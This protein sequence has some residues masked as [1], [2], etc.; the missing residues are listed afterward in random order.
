MLKIYE[1]WT[2]KL[3][4]SSV[5][6]TSAPVYANSTVAA[7]K[8]AA[9]AG[10]V[11]TTAVVKSSPSASIMAASGA[12]KAMAVSGASLAGLLGLAAYIL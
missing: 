12:N 5:A 9:S 8:T 4:C 6:G 7:S 3:T 1:C 2:I 11:G 10:S